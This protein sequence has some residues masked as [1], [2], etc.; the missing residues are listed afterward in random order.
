MSTHHV[1]RH[2]MVLG[3]ALVGWFAGAGSAAEPL[4]TLSTRTGKALA[5]PRAAFN[6]TDGLYL[7]VHEY[8]YGAADWDIDGRVVDANGLAPNEAFGIAWNGSIVQQEPDIAYNPVAN[9]FL[10]VYALAPDNWKIS[11]CI[12]AGDGTPGPFIPIA[13][14]VY[15]E[16]HPSVACDPTTGEYLVVYEREYQLDSVEWREVWAQRVLQ[17]GTLIADPYRISYPGTDS[18][19]CA[20]ACAGGQYMVVWTEQQARGKGR[21]LG[22]MIQF[23]YPS[24]TTF[25]LAQARDSVRP[26]IAYNPARAEYLVVYQT[27]TG[28]G[29][30]WSIEGVRINTV[31]EIKDATLIASPVEAH[32]TAPDVA[33]TPADGRYVVTWIQSTSESPSLLPSHQI[34]ALGIDGGGLPVGEPLP[35]SEPG[36]LGVPAP[37]IAAGSCGRALIVWDEQSDPT[38]S[39]PTIYS[40][41][42]AHDVWGGLCTACDCNCPQ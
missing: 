21:I 28:M 31:G 33:C 20:V 3:L 4:L 29:A 14:S 32:C 35:V 24:K 8:H 22:R 40:I 37:A 11:A 30:H 36:M 38:D 39:S 26:Q 16:Y 2:R 34:M 5:A 19:D 25:T 12:V 15:R 6:T 13:T 9:E 17:T 27:R 10:V 18:R 1:P 41:R 7:T 42:G 23:G